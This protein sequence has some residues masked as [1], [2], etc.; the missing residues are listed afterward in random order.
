[1]NAVEAVED[2]LRAAGVPWRRVASGEWGLTASAGDCDLHVGV[3]LRAGLVCAQAEALGAGAPGAPD[4][5]ALLHRNRTL[6]LVRFAHTRAGAVQVQGEVPAPAAPAHVDRLLGALV[7]AAD[8]VRRAA[9]AHAAPASSAA[10]SPGG[11]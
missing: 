8:D 6:R 2:A 7:Q 10:I 1:M 3:A 9:G 5:H 11:A 4:P